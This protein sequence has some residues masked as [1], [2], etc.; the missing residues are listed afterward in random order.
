VWGVGC[1][2]LGRGKREEGVLKLITVAK[3]LFKIEEIL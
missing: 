2:V 3:S 1:G